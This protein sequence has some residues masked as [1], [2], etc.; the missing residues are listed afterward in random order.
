MVSLPAILELLKHTKGRVLA[1]AEMAMAESQYRAFRR[2]F[3]NILGREG[4]ERDLVK[5][6]TNE[7]QQGRGGR[8]Q[9]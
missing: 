5:L 8:G 4:L 3:L 2:E 9:E 1:C 6:F 7:G